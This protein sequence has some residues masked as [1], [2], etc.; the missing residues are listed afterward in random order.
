MELMQKPRFEQLSSKARQQLLESCGSV[1][2]TLGEAM[3]KQFIRSLPSLAGGA[4]LT[5]M[6]ADCLV[7]PAANLTLVSKVR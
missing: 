6:L 2:G 3:Q 4:D 5:A 1:L 7:H